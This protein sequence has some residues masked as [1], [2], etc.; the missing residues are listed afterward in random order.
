MS[1]VFSPSPRTAAVERFPNRKLSISIPDDIVLDQEDHKKKLTQSLR[2]RWEQEI[3]RFKDKTG[4]DLGSYK[5]GQVSKTGVLSTLNKQYGSDSKDQKKRDE[6]YGTIEKIINGV[7]LV[8]AIAAQAASVVFGPAQ[9]C[10]N[11]L[12]ILF[13]IPKAMKSFHEELSKLF[14]EVKDYLAKFNVYDRIDQRGMLDVALVTSNNE[15][16]VA[17]VDLCMLAWHAVEH[18]TSFMLGKVFLNESPISAAVDNFGELIKKQNEL[19]STMTLEAVLENGALTRKIL[20]RYTRLEET[21]KR[22]EDSVKDGNVV[23]KDT[24]VVVKGLAADNLE[25][26]NLKVDRDRILK[27]DKAL[28][29]T[30]AMVNDPLES[31]RLA[32]KLLYDEILEVLKGESDFTDWDDYDTAD[33]AKARKRLLY[34]GGEASTGKTKLLSALVQRID[35]RRKAL[36]EKQQEAR[37]NKSLRDDRSIYVVYYSFVASGKGRDR[38]KRFDTP[39]HTALKAMAAQLARQSTRYANALSDILE[40]LQKRQMTLD[41]IWAAL[42][43]HEYDAPAFSVLYMF[44]DGL[45]QLKS[46]LPELGK[47][48]KTPDAQK[49]AKDSESGKLRL[50]VVF[51]GK[52]DNNKKLDLDSD[53]PMINIANINTP[54]IKSYVDVQL[55]DR[56]IFQDDDEASRERRA[57]VLDLIPSNCNGSFDVADQKLKLLE[58]AIEKDRDS[59]EL[60]SDLESAT[61]NSVADE[62]RKILEKLSIELSEQHRAQL[63]ELLIWTIYA[64]RR[65]ELGELEGALY[66]QRNKTSLEPLRRKITGRFEEA[67]ELIDD[68]VYPRDPIEEAIKYSDYELSTSGAHEDKPKILVDLSLKNADESSLKQFVRDLNQRIS[69]GA[70]DFSSHLKQSEAGMEL[71]FG[72]GVA[73]LT[74]VSRLLRALNDD[75]VRRQTVA[76]VRYACRNLPPHLERFQDDYMVK[77]PLQDVVAVAKGLVNFLSDS[78]SI[79]YA[80]DSLSFEPY[81]WLSDSAIIAIK[82]ILQHKN[83]LEELDPIERRW[84]IKHTE[85]TTKKASFYETL[86]RV[87][88][89]KWLIDRAQKASARDCYSFIIDY[90]DMVSFGGRE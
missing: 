14:R 8:G 68:Y 50:R 90:L 59:D 82:T 5:N 57:K 61:F 30:D 13:S 56:T 12:D 69:D 80:W 33:E 35:A 41:E 86:L 47:I 27:I 55:Q 32:K 84:A 45:D 20:S 78:E 1:T 26:K 22:I 36:H 72:P 40:E 74:I 7:E 64:E 19:T 70:F 87:V 44:F 18:K 85:K 60:M 51:T 29:L 81:E 89:E 21:T 11:A 63:R 23:G 9:M 66:L 6:V 3:R 39:V 77:T 31:L 65:P 62:G 4:F 28:D 75:R 52:P 53:L 71:F 38:E 43:M 15:I 10:F 83:A 54:L 16:L 73:E 88:A 79:A 2:Q 37:E 24:N 67:L 42:K 76:L 46:S 34:I 58:T 25:S 17:F 49:K 48:F